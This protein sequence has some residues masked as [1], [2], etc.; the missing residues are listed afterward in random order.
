MTGKRLTREEQ[1]QCL[2]EYSTSG[3]S[4]RDYAR[5]KKVGY[6]TLQEWSARF[7]IPLSRSKHASAKMLGV[8]APPPPFS[9][10]NIT[11]SLPVS[12]CS[13]EIRM[14][15]GIEVKMESLALPHAIELIK[16]LT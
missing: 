10:I 2:Q 8:H 5:L 9:F 1:I 6:S 14:P 13:M 11:P 4:V 16:S 15:T 3:L 12:L 7:G